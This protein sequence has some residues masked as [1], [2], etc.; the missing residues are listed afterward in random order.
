MVGNPEDRFSQ[1]EAHIK[2][3]RSLDA[4]QGHS[5]PVQVKEPYIG[6]LKG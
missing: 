5:P 4:V 3:R 2:E 6:N 1:N